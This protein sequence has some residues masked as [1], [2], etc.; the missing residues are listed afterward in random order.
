MSDQK[1]KQWRISFTIG[2]YTYYT[3]DLVRSW[4]GKMLTDRELI[5]L[6]IEEV[7]D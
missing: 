3:V 7:Q 6:K 4:I 5:T 2:T 1:F